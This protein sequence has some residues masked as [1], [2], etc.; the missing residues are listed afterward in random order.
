M[1]IFLEN[2]VNI[3]V[4]DIYLTKKKFDG[5]FSVISWFLRN[6]TYHRSIFIA[7]VYVHHTHLFSTR[8]I[9]QIIL[10]AIKTCFLAFFARA[11]LC[12]SSFACKLLYMHSTLK[13]KVNSCLHFIFCITTI[14]LNLSEIR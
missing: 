12:I 6:P 11:Q 4:T 14:M 5:F 1:N 7:L 3:C 10:Y 2:Y 8:L 9:F 13:A